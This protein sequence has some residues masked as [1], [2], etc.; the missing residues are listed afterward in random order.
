MG[1]GRNRLDWFGALLA[2]KQWEPYGC[3]GHNG[4]WL[5][6]VAQ[7]R[8]K[9]E[10]RRLIQFESTRDPLEILH[11]FFQLLPISLL[12]HSLSHSVNVSI[13]QRLMSVSKTSYSPFISFG[14]FPPKKKLSYSKQ[15]SG[16]HFHYV[17]L[18][19]IWPKQQL[20]NQAYNTCQHKSVVY[21]WISCCS[22]RREKKRQPCF[23]CSRF[24]ET[25]NALECLQVK[26]NWLTCKRSQI[27]ACTAH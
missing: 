8:S 7:R 6:E 18:I 21:S 27:W 1:F 4:L 15:S 3:Y 23:D 26:K 12:S 13:N 5:G 20:V 14:S 19:G 17:I 2:R 9:S 22:Q 10:N 24:R 25:N 11:A 16:Y